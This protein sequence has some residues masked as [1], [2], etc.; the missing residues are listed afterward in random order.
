MATPE[1]LDRLYDVIR[2]RANASPDESYVAKLL[3]GGVAA[4]AAKLREES[5]ELIEAAGES[6]KAHTAQEAGD[7][8]F[9][10]WVLLAAV[11][12][13]PAAVFAELERRFGTSGLAEKAARGAGS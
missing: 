12:V 9:H 8:L 1:I 3:A 10:T 4:I 2:E 7:L 13:E 5:E 6:D 11:G